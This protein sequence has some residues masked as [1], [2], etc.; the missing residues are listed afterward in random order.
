MPPLP[1]V[2]Y[3]PAQS[4]VCV[5]TFVLTHLKHSSLSMYST[6]LSVYCPDTSTA[7]LLC[8]CEKYALCF[9]QTEVS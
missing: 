5:I 6:E 7:L 2:G 3:Q 8:S 4:C 9:A 1:A